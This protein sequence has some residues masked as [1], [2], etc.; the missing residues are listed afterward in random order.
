MFLQEGLDNKWIFLLYSTFQGIHIFNK[1]REIDLEGI[2]L[3]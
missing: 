2:T 3:F 1:A